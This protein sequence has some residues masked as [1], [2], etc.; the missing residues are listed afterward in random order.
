MLQHNSSRRNTRNNKMSLLDPPKTD[1]ITTHLNVV[2][3][4]VCMYGDVKVAL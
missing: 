1:I 3:M 4:Y 2:C